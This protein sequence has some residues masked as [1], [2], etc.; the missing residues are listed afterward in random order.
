MRK[1]LSAVAL[2][3]ALAFTLGAVA[4]APAEAAGNCFY[5]CSCTGTPLRCCETSTGG[6]ACK[7]TN[8]IR[9]PQIITC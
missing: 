6:V 7:P 8:D 9:C 5:K 1:V 3:F 2:V 4:P